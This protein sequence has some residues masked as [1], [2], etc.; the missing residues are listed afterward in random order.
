MS[1]RKKK[2]EEHVNLE[3][4]LVSYADFI[5][6]LFAFFVVMYSISSVNEGKY[7]ILSDTLNVVFESRPSSPTPI[8]HD[9]IPIPVTP[10]NQLL[11]NI[12]V[13]ERLP[14]PEED[15]NSLAVP[16]NPELDALSEEIGQAVKSLIDDELISIKKTDF[17]LEIDIKSS[18]LFGSGNAQLSEDAEDVLA[19]IARLLDSYPN[20][21]QVEGFTDNRPIKSKK[22]PSNWELSSSRAASVVHLFEE[23]GIDPKRMQ[24]IGYSQYRPVAD[25]ATAAG[26]NA[27]RRVN[28][29]VLGQG[30]PRQIMQQRI[31][32]LNQTP[33]KT[34]I[35]KIKDKKQ[36]FNPVFDTQ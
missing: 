14:S 13:P 23:E 36:R 33:K 26:R 8:E 32:S 4:W 29:V 11:V 1:R 7:R 5:T 27:N 20:D 2:H 18:I 21:I 25:N 17:W 19:T 24:A 12:P 16:D 31:K 9:S 35:R 10:S 3:R 28:L 6:L 34:S 30:D 15:G 22:F